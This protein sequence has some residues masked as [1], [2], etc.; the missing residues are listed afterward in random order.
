MG[1]EDDCGAREAAEGSVMFAD[2]STGGHR[3][4]TARRLGA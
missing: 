3:F 2:A 4:D 1:A